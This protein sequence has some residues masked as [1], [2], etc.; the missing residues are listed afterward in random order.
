MGEDYMSTMTKP[1][2][3]M[4]DNTTAES[5]DFTLNQAAHVGNGMELTE[6]DADEDAKRFPRFLASLRLLPSSSGSAS[7]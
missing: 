2:A 4:A 1:G 7:G 6:E 5:E 3:A